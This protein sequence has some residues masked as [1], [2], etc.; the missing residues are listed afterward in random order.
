MVC[1]PQN[2]EPKRS[3]SDRPLGLSRFDVFRMETETDTLLAQEVMQF[4][5]KSH[6]LDIDAAVLELDDMGKDWKDGSGVKF[7]LTCLENFSF[8]DM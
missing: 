1:Q 2:Y 7:D 6:D 5:L 8:H 4:I 3:S